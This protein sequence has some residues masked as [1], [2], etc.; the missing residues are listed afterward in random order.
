M[1]EGNDRKR[2]GKGRRIEKKLRKERS[3]EGEKEGEKLREEGR[4]LCHI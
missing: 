1:I 2:E 4:R 3:G